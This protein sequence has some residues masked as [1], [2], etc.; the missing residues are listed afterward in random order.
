MYIMSLSFTDH[1]NGTPVAWVTNEDKPKQKKQVFM[2]DHKTSE[3]E[4]ELKLE[5]K[6][7]FEKAIDVSQEREVLY[8]SGM[9]GAGK[10]YFCRQY[11]ERYRKKYPK[12]N[13]FVFSSLPSCKTLDKLKY[14]KR[15]K[16]NESEFMSRVVTAPDFKDSLVLFDD[17]DVISN[18]RI[19]AKVYEVMNSILQI[20]R[21]HDATALVTSHNVT[22]GQET[23][24]VLNEATSIVLFPKASG[25]KSLL[26]ISDSYLGLDSKQAKELK[27]IE[28]RFVCVVRAHPRCVFSLKRIY[29]LSE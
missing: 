12:R 20:G 5:G 21:H 22:N 11:I 19:K 23:K 28:G 9:S 24:I 17:I 13:V 7:C 2:Y 29:L 16:I 26:Y 10:S 3:G 14:L 18:K 15:I 4:A 8:V 1:G 27:K 25:N 6:D